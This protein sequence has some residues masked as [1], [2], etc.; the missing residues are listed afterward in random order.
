MRN[1]NSSAA[2]RR[3]DSQIVTLDLHYHPFPTAALYC[4]LGLA[5]VS[6]VILILHLLEVKPV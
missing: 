4:G 1:K 2:G 6:L 5:M 3:Q